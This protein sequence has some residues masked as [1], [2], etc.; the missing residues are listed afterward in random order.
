[1]TTANAAFLYKKKTPG[2]KELKPAG[3]GGPPPS[4]S[5]TKDITHCTPVASKKKRVKIMHERFIRMMATGLGTGLSPVAPGTVGTLLGIPLYLVFIRFPWPV[6]LFSIITFA[7]FAVYISQEAERIYH[8]KDPGRIVID[9]IA[10]FQVTMFLVEPTLWHILL[11]F[12]L[13]RLFD[14]TKPFPI[15]LCERNL[16][17]GY[18]VVGDDLA[19]G[20]YANIILLFLVRC[21][22]Q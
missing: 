1:L 3:K 17:G 15:R 18:G 4:Y 6:A 21:V 20:V 22:M 13:F 2:V 5:L 7:F 10:G 19:A 14:I 11:G 16:P 8:E 9:E 12:F